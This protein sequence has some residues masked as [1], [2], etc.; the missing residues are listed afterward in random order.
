MASAQLVQLA[1]RAATAAAARSRYVCLIDAAA[2]R[3]AKRPPAGPAG[4]P[5]S[6][7]PAAMPISETTTSWF[8]MITHHKHKAKH[9]SRRTASRE[10]EEEETGSECVCA[11]LREFE[12]WVEAEWERTGYL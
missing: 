10:E 7:A 12:R 3:H 8:V 6:A 5:G 2:L 1:E 9:S 11:L 4:P